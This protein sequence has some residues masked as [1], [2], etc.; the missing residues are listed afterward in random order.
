MNIYTYIGLAIVITLIVGYASYR[1]LTS[2]HDK[3][4]D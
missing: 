1:K 2:F 3:K 4:D